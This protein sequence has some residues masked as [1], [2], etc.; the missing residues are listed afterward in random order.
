MNEIEGEVETFRINVLLI[1]KNFILVSIILITQ[2]TYF[3]QKNPLRVASY[4]ILT[5]GVLYL[6]YNIIS[7][8]LTSINV[9]KKEHKVNF[10]FQQIPN[11]HKE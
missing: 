1:L 5:V 9:Y 2:Y 10:Q 3:F 7:E 6:L 11:F 4:L 8:T